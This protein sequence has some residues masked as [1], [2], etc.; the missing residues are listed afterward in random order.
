[1]SSISNVYNYYLTNYGASA[2][3]SKYEAHKRSELRD[4]YNRMVK[5]NKESPLYKIDMNE[6]VE[7]FALDLKES[8]RRT[9]NIVS[10]LS[11]DGDDMRG[12]LNRK[13]AYTSDPEA[14]D[15]TY[16]GDH[17]DG[18]G[19][20]Q[21]VVNKLAKPQV[22]EGNYLRARGHDFREGD[23]SFDLDTAKTS[24]E[25]QFQVEGTETNRQVQE[26][27]AD[28]MNKAH[29]G[30]TAELVENENRE[31][32]LRLT[33]NQT[34][35][36]DGEEYL[37]RVQSGSSWDEVHRLG[38]DQITSQ[39]SNASF[40]LNGRERTALSN[41]FTINNAFGVTLKGET[42]GL[43]TV[44]FK[45][46]T[47]AASDSVQHLVDAYNNFAKVGQAYRDASGNSK[48]YNE[49]TAVARRMDSELSAVGLHTDRDGIL[50]VD[51]DRLANVLTSDVSDD[52]LDT[53]NKFKNS[54]SR[55]S[56]RAGIDPMMYVNKLVVAYK[57]PGKTFSAPYAA[58]L[59]AGLLVNMGL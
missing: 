36:A 25:F 20:F 45:S 1:M 4:T 11:I 32:A 13:I 26:K 49:I 41:Q 33:S 7:K 54:L 17:S 29:V 9:D 39:A 53:L 57:N 5:A 56:K 48:L 16:I 46:N 15:V 55:E 44:G 35:L 28:L 30:I 58:S 19:G 18:T 27:I 2:T 42:N 37:F 14:V 40:E 12:V 34:G 51:R 50:S 24:Y 22:T 43:V 21:I 3:S 52:A 6:D 10:E 47:E 31:T 23:Y 8:A 59:Y 38:L